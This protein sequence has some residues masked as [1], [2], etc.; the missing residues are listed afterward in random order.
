MYVLKSSFSVHSYTRFIARYPT[1]VLV[2]VASLSVAALTATLLLRDLPDF[3]D[4]Q[5]V[6]T[7]VLYIHRLTNFGNQL[8]SS[9]LPR[10]KSGLIILFL[11]LSLL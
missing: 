3:T 5:A 6:R 4:P 1:L 8:V 2:T 7:H 9:S 11:F 10:Q